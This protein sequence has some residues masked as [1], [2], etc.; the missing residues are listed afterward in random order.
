MQ[1]N[2]DFQSL[3]QFL[4]DGFSESADVEARELQAAD[5]QASLLYVKPLCDSKLIAKYIVSPFW[6][7]QTEAEYTG[8][9]MSFPNCVHHQELDTTI[10]LILSGYVGVFVADRLYLYEAKSIQVSPVAEATVES[11]VQGPQDA[12]N[13]SLMTNLNLVRIRYKSD[14]LQV[15]YQNVGERSKT[16][17]ALLYDK[18]NVNQQALAELRREL[19]EIDLKVLLSAGH[20]QNTLLR[21]KRWSL[22]PLV[23]IT[24][25]PDR[26]VKNLSEGKIIVLIDTTPFAVILPSSFGD[27]FSAMDDYTQLP[28]IGWFLRLLRYIGFLSTIILPGLYV[29]TIS[30]NP[31]FFRVQLAFS[32]VASRAA[33][34]YASYLEVIFMLLM[35]EFLTEASVRLP[36]A[37]GPTATTV[38]GLILGQAA[39]QAGLISNI[40]IIIVSVV[41]ISNYVIPII[42]MNFAVRVLKYLFVLL[43]TVAG[44]IGIIIGAILLVFY[45]SSL[46][47][48]GTP[49][50]K[51]VR[52][53]ES[54]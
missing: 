24:E 38:G 14:L 41:G 51:M 42:E 35:M 4:E 11:T 52:G 45:L 12:F 26:A 33:V 18:Q 15:D 7:Y 36:R 54:K 13:E 49:Y 29:A 22:F 17:L 32:I 6:D 47:S 9:L 2:N 20:L 23:V 3:K 21:R 46:T 1:R 30:Y 50:L 48:F 19:D 5:K 39:T 40:M 27:F 10:N 43:A 28:L 34:P 25:R 16:Q 53:E 8:F 44:L 37:I 31:E